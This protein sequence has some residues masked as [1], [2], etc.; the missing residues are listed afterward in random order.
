M[1]N[2]KLKKK[3][4]VLEGKVNSLELNVDKLLKNESKA[5]NN[6]PYSIFDLYPSTYSYQPRALRSDLRIPFVTKDEDGDDC[7]EYHEMSDLVLSIMQYLRLK[8]EKIDKKDSKIEMREL[9][10]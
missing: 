5:Y 10:L 1:F 3:I 8:P 6:S 9:D 7:S 4:E 2:K